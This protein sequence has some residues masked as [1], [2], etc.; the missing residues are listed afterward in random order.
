MALVDPSPD[1]VIRPDYGELACALCAML[2]RNNTRKRPLMPA[3][4]REVVS[5]MTSQDC[6]DHT[7]I[8]KIFDDILVTHRTHTQP[9]RRDFPAPIHLFLPGDSHSAR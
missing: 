5:S 2:V 9:N 8:H 1:E 7:H 3:F 6:A 4:N